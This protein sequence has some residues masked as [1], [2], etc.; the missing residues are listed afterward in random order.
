MIMPEAYHAIEHL[1][2]GRPIEIRAVRPDDK[3]D[4]LAAI[5]RTSAESLRRR[6]FGVKRGFSQEEI[7]FFMK[8]IRQGARDNLRIASTETEHHHPD[9]SFAFGWVLPLCL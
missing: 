4:M 2:D 8:L 3:D 9:I 1:R 6:F 7:D 5:G